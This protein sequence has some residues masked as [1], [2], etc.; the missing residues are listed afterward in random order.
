MLSTIKKLAA[1][2]ALTLL[3]ACG[4]GGG[5]GGESSVTDPS[6]NFPL[7][8]A[9]SDYVIAG[10]SEYFL[11]AGTLKNSDGSFYTANG[12]IQSSKTAASSVTF[13]GRNAVR[14]SN[15]MD[16][17]VTYSNVLINGIKNTIVKPFPN[18]SSFFYWDAIT[19]SE[20]GFI[21]DSSYNVYTTVT[22]TPAFIKVGQQGT[23]STKVKYLN[24]TKSTRQ[25]TST[26]TYEVLPDTASSVII[27]LTEISYDSAGAYDSTEDNFYRVSP[28]HRLV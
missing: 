26:T 25:G 8:Q 7:R 13:E 15:T 6:I 16:G 9:V 1:L 10:K 12:E 14:Y 28:L 5:G 27:K 23:L 22:T 2:V 17:N 21:S 20:L 3:T 18:N 24:I 4:G 19:Y 11:I